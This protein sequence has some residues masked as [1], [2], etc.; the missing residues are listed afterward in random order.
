VKL[1]LALAVVLLLRAAFLNQAIQGDDAYYLAFAEHAQIDPVHPL[2]FR[3]VFQ[4]ELV[5]MEG[6]SH[7]PLNAWILGALLAMVG[8]IRE[9]PFH[10]GYIL[11][12]LIAVAS[13]WSLARRSRQ[14]LFGRRCSSSRHR[15]S[16]LM[17]DSLESDL[18]FLAF[19]MAGRGACL[20]PSVMRWQLIALALA[21]MAAYQG[22]LPDADSRGVCL[23][24]RAPVESRV[25]AGAAPLLVIAGWQTVRARHNRKGCRSR[26]FRAISRHINS[27]RDE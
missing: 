14:I 5:D 13:M 21:S 11:L 3:S 16:S 25:G 9:V 17:E 26:S 20:S 8:D 10:A 23:A 7:P 4:G 15:R 12:S 19:W 24:L 27:S 2:N 6:H 18:P 1:L 22:N